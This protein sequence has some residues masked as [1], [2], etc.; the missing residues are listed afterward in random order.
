[1]EETKKVTITVRLSIEEKE[2]LD[3][4]SVAKGMNA[5]EYVRFVLNSHCIVI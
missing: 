3:R 5:S 4:I 1:M 2:E